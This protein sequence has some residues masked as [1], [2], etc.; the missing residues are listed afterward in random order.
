MTEVVLFHSVRGLRLAEREWADRLRAAGH[1]VA[2][3]DLY[4]GE[5]GE[6]LEAGFAI[7]E[8]IGWATMVARARAATAALPAGTV[9]AGVSVG[10]QIVG[11]GVAG[12]AGRRRRPAAARAM[13]GAG[14]AARRASGAGA[15]GR[16][17]ALRRRGLSRR[18]G[19]GHAAGRARLPAV[20]LS[21]APGT[22]SPTRPCPT[23]TPTAHA[24]AEERVLAFLAP[25]SERPRRQVTFVA[26]SLTRETTLHRQ[27]G[28]GR[29][30]TPGRPTDRSRMSPV[31]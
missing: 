21:R 5:T 7:Q 11:R 15:H 3:P 6:T 23:T 14:E 18:L 12:P 24:L 1:T 31:R 22:I 20:P 29:K 13:R 30:I 28:C 25:A 8:R 9:L 16:S 17:R 26:I 10:A 4:G 2:L 27:G 19:R